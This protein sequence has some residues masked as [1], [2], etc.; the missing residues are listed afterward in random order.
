MNEKIEELKEYISKCE[1]C[2][3]VAEAKELEEEIVS[4]F[5]KE[6]ENIIS[7]LDYY[8]PGGIFNPSRPFDNLEDIRILKAKLENYKVSIE[9]KMKKHKK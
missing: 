2:K 5:G 7:G 6:I 3:E 9:C 4:V 1:N 8:G